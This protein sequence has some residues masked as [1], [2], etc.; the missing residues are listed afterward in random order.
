MLTR[1]TNVWSNVG[2]PQPQPPVTRVQWHMGLIP[3]R[4]SKWNEAPWQLA[5]SNSHNRL[6]GSYW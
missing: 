1:H 6:L 5:S 4:L 2:Q 3:L